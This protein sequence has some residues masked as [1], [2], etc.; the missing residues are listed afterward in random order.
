[1]PISNFSDPVYDA[2]KARL[3]SQWTDCPIQ[4]PNETWN[5]APESAFIKFE[6]EFLYYA[7]QSI[8]A[9]E[10]ADNRWDGEGSIT[11]YLQVPRGT[12]ITHAYGAAR[13]LARIFRG[14]TALG[15]DLEFGEAAISP[16]P[17][18]SDVG[19]WFTI[20]VRIEWRNTNA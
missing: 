6:Y 19:G 14:F 16:N 18:N 5:Q 9:D 15:G 4:W 11:M 3:V 13:Q 8:G 17:F 10:Q 2:I 20:P 7:Q 12:D 1:M